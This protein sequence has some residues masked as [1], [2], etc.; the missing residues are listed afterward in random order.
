[1]TDIVTGALLLTGALFLLV[2]AIGLLKLPDLYMRISSTTKASV[3]SVLFVLAAGV[4]YFADLVV[5][6]KVIAVIAFAGLTSPVAAHMIGRAAYR[7]GV[8]LWDRTQFDELKSGK[9]QGVGKGEK[10]A[11]AR[12]EPHATG[13]TRRRAKPTGP[14]PAG[15]RTQGPGQDS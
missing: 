11:P 3:V 1:M 14:K 2:A 4:V 12:P 10:S 9:G 13:V 15:P 8:P 7:D 5:T 6:T